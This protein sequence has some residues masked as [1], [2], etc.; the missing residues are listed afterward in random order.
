MQKV[1][2]RK[3]S[4]RLLA[5][6]AAGG[7][8]DQTRLEAALALARINRSRGLAALRDIE[9]DQRISRSVKEKA[10]KAAE[11]LDR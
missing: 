4:E 11:R 3:T 1:R 5:A 2:D 9:A 6:M 7:K 10:T 8:S